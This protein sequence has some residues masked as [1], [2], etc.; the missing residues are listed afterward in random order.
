[1]T[2]HQVQLIEVEI[3]RHILLALYAK[4]PQ[5]TKSHLEVA[6]ALTEALVAAEERRVEECRSHKSA[7][8][9]GLFRQLLR[10]SRR[11]QAHN[12]SRLYPGP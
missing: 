3:S 7:T 10:E 12:G 5:I 6:Q 4:E 1:M 9:I 2:A 11:A 8:N